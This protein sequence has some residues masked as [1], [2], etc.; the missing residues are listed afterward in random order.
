M[1]NSRPIWFSAPFANFD[2]VFRTQHH[3][4]CAELVPSSPLH[5]RSDCDCRPIY[6]P[7]GEVLQNGLRMKTLAR[8]CIVISGY[9]LNGT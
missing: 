7:T 9:D 4:Y 6:L 2:P 8:T 3:L 1:L 5:R